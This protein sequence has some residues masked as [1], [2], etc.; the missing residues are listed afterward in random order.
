MAEHARC[1]WLTAE[2]A[3]QRSRILQA[4]YQKENSA[5]LV[6]MRTGAKW[7]QCFG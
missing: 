5:L 3:L 7:H 1:I 6:C 4:A 2:Q